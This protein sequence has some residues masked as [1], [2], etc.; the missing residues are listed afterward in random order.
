MAKGRRPHRLS[1]GYNF[2]GRIAAC[3][4][5]TQ[6]VTWNVSLNLVASV[7]DEW[8]ARLGEDAKRDA[9]P[10][11]GQVNAYGAK[12]WAS[13]SAVWTFSRWEIFFAGLENRLRVM[14]PENG[15]IIHS[16]SQGRS[17]GSGVDPRTN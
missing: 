5:L 4:V 16:G 11:A 13:P 6:V 9:S 12:P 7:A 15:A 14:S 10:T 17:K 3:W 1:I 8:F 2:T